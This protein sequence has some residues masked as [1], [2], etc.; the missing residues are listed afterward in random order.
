MDRREFIGAMVRGG[1]L[2]VAYMSS[3][4]SLLSRFSQSDADARLRLTKEV[5]SS[6]DKKETVY[7]M[8]EYSK[9]ITSKP[10]VVIKETSEKGLINILSENP[11]KNSV[12]F[13]EEPF[14]AERENIIDTY[15]INVL[16]ENNA[17]S[18]IRIEADRPYD[19]EAPFFTA[20]DSE[21]NGLGMESGAIP[22]HFGFSKVSVVLRKNADSEDLKKAE[23][24]Y[25]KIVKEALDLLT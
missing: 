14:S 19:A 7:D 10:V 12:T 5:I 8:V 9:K 21:V 24:V 13:F 1:L 20:Y 25:S 15:S 23:I 16:V 6:Y 4:D 17:V 2:S 22:D 11:A 3:L 18:G